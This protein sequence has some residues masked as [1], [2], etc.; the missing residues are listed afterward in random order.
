[1]GPE[2]PS[3]VGLSIFLSNHDNQITFT[4]MCGTKL[5]FL[6]FPRMYKFMYLVAY[7][8]EGF[9]QIDQ[10]TVTYSRPEEDGR[11]PFFTV[12]TIRCNDGFLI[13]GRV[14]PW[15]VV[16][17]KWSGGSPTCVPGKKGTN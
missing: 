7:T 13:S 16:P 14:A 5:V 3:K 1:M 8:C 10:L 12:A 11:Y 15:C 9:P 6:H 4:W 17:G 2:V